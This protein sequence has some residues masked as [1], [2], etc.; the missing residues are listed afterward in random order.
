MHVQW[1]AVQ[2]VFNILAGTEH[3]LHV[4]IDFPDVKDR[5]GA[6]VRNSTK[7]GEWLREERSMGKFPF[8]AGIT[9]DLC[10]RAGV[11]HAEILID[12]AQFCH[13]IYRDGV[14]PKQA[15]QM[16]IVGDL[17][18]QK[19]EFRERSTGSNRS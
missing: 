15:D 16:T 4:R 1:N 2:F 9:A 6:I 5:K 7:D 11:K 3:L 14:L 8:M 19:F 13:F 10:I 12:G 17:T 18:I